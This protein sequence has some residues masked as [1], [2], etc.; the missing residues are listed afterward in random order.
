MSEKASSPW[1]SHPRTRMVFTKAIQI[2]LRSK[3]RGS[4]LNLSQLYNKRLVGTMEQ[5]IFGTNAGKQLS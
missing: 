2:L 1:V 4:L 5:S 3:L